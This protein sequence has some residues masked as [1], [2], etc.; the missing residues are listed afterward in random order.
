MR[1]YAERGFTLVEV[2]VAL[3]VLA[4]AMVAWQL[5]ITA[6]LESAAYLRDKTLAQW[7][8]L[9]QLQYLQLA[10]RLGEP[11]PDSLRTGTARMADRTWYW[12]LTPLAPAPGTGDSTL[13][14]APVPVVI[15]VSDDSADAARSNPLTTMTGV[16]A[17]NATR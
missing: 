10:S 2:L 1:R 15:A 8:A 16:V 5:R 17:A 4:L 13:E 6:Q 11:A 12:Q 3:L 14:Q 9:N 7:V